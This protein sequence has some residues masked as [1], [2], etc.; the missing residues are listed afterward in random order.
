MVVSFIKIHLGNA[1][2]SHRSVIGQN[3]L[4]KSTVYTHTYLESVISTTNNVQTVLMKPKPGVTSEQLADVAAQVK[5]MVK[6]IPLVRT[7]EA[8]ESYASTAHR[9]KGF[10]LGV[11]VV[12]DKAEDLQAYSDHP[13]HGPYVCRSHLRLYPVSRGTG[14]CGKSLL[15]F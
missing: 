6:T 15:V 12:L 8:G 10:K 14:I 13:A 9:N 5:A 3:L 11:I 2:L 4:L 7:L 1:V